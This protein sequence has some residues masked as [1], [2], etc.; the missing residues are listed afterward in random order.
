M[1]LYKRVQGL[2][3]FSAVTLRWTPESAPGG[4]IFFDFFKLKGERNFKLFF[5]LDQVKNNLRVY[6]KKFFI[7]LYSNFLIGDCFSK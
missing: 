5:S 6:S 3:I 4:D 2:R 1:L 7:K